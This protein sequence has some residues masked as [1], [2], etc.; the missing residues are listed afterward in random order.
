MLATPRRNH[1]PAL[2]SATLL[3]ALLKRREST[4]RPTQTIDHK[5]TTPNF[6]AKQKLCPASCCW[7]AGDINKQSKAEPHIVCQCRVSIEA[8]CA[9]LSYANN[10]DRVRLFYVAD[11]RNGSLFSPPKVLCLHYDERVH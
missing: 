2:W 4:V 9:F 11:T 6:G 7:R 10:M 5:S 8:F 1:L 3:L